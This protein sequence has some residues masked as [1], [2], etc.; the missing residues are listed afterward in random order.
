MA[1]VPVG[2][3]TKL[4]PARH[5]CRSRSR[6]MTWHSNVP[7]VMSYWVDQLRDQNGVGEKLMF[8]PRF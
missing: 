8:T 7:L 5:S 1:K 2:F 3:L 6:R 4:N